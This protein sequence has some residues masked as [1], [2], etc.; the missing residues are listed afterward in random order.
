MSRF[1]SHLKQ[2]L[3]KINKN[4]YVSK[5]D[6]LY[7]EKMLRYGK[8]SSPE[9]HFLKAK[10]LEREG[11]L[12]KALIHYNEAAHIYSPYYTKAKQ[13]LQELEMKMNSPIIPSQQSNPVKK[14]TIG[15]PLIITLLVLN[16]FLLLLLFWKD[17]ISSVVSDMKQWEIGKAVVY[18]SEDV[19]YTIYLPDDISKE[20]IQKVVYDEVLSLSEGA[21]NQNI[22][23][24]GISTDDPALYHHVSPLRQEQLKE[25]AFVMAEY[26]PSL[27][28]LVQVRFQAIKE[29]EVPPLS[30]IGVNIVRTALDNYIDDHGF[31]PLE[32]TALVEDYPENYLSF[33]PNEVVSKSNEVSTTFTNMG[34]WVYDPKALTMSAMF[35]PNDGQ[36]SSSI[37]YKPVE[38]VV[39]KA[40]YSLLVLADP[41]II[42]KVKVGLGKEDQTPEGKFE[43]KDRV[44]NPKGSRADIFGVAGLGMGEIAVHGTYDENSI[45]KQQSL[46]C[47]RLLN[48]DMKTIYSVVPKGTEVTIV[49]EGSFGQ[50]SS[51]QSLEPLIPEEQRNIDET[52]ATVFHWL[53]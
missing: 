39:D 38:V 4:I 11:A 12:G 10:Q 44:I 52:T 16:I 37:P 28:D 13:S 36:S 20:E 15:K 53:D 41:Y 26:N 25:T 32:I 45:Q 49:K 42:S 47:I 33:I 5:S 34:G 6:A 8:H 7:Y 1:E 50:A 3:V 29:P 46:G 40:S 18:A 30:Y 9:A 35:Y 43:I 48:E 21:V 27:D 51:V 24:Y 31:P 23:L 14:R 2:H 19:P 17:P 22:Q